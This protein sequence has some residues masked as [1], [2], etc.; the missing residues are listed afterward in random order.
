MTRGTARYPLL[1]LVAQIDPLNLSGILERLLPLRL[2]LGSGFRV[3]PNLTPV[4]LL[5]LI[6]GP[7]VAALNSSHVL[8]MIA[9]Q[10]PNASSL[11]QQAIQK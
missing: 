3:A 10:P 11:K 5:A 6:G 8:S 4:E 9:S 2:G 1:A 7:F